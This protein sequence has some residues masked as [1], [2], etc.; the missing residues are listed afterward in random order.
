MGG[1]I[2]K[3]VMRLT[4]AACV[5]LLLLA[6]APA[7]PPSELIGTWRGTSLCTDRVAA[8]NCKDEVVIYE[9]TPAANPKDVHWQA[10]KVVN[11]KRL[12]MGEFDL[13][14]SQAEGCWKAELEQY[15]IVWRV[16]VDGKTLNGTLTQVPGKQVVRKITARKD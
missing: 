8:P 2:L 11:G 15:R 16:T 14:Y 13:T 4:V 9:F 3:G 6:A 5:S 1:V 12:N 7:H 10:D